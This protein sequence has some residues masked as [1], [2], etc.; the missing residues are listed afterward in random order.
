MYESINLR[1]SITRR[2]RKET[3]KKERSI[4]VRKSYRKK[5]NETGEKNESKTSSGKKRE[6]IKGYEMERTEDGNFANNLERTEIRGMEKIAK[7]CVE[8]CKY[9]N[10]NNWTLKCFS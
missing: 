9:H 3:S 8:E 5:V 6:R 4:I 2:E 7:K 10:L 1:K